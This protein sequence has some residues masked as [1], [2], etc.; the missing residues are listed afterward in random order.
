MRDKYNNPISVGSEVHY[1]IPGHG[2]GG[3]Y[4]FVIGVMKYASA[5]ED[6]VCLATAKEIGMPINTGH[7]TVMSGIDTHAISDPMRER[8]LQK[9][10]GALK[11]WTNPAR[12]N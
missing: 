9:F 10:P 11:P 1:Y 8:Y 7:L 12:E 5:D 3:G 6:V 2:G 4:A